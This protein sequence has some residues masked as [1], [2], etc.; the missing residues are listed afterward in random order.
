[1]LL[2]DVHGFEL[3][4]WDMSVG[5]K[6]TT[7]LTKP[8]ADPNHEIMAH[9]LVLNPMLVGQFAKMISALVQS[10]TTAGNCLRPVQLTRQTLNTITGEVQSVEM[11]RRCQSR[12]SEVCPSCSKLYRADAFAVIRAG[13]MGKDGKPRPMTMI[14]LTAPGAG[15][16]GQVHSR[17]IM[18]NGSVKPCACRWVRH[19]ENDPI[20]GTPINPETYNYAAA[21][22]FNAHA[23]RLFAVSMQKLGR[24]LRRKIQVVRVVEYQNRGLVHVH[25]LVL[26]CLTQE[27]LKLIVSG[28]RNLRTGRKVRPATS[29][30]WMWGPQCRAK[31]VAGGNPGQAIAYMV[32]VVSYA[33][34]DA[35]STLGKRNTHENKMARA[36]AETCSSNVSASGC[37]HG[38]RLHQIS[39]VEHNDIGEVRSTET[40]IYDNGKRSEYP[41]RRHKRAAAG[42]GH[43]G[44]VLTKTRSWPETFAAVRAKRGEWCERNRNRPP[45][46][47]HLLVSWSVTP[48]RRHSAWAM[49][50]G[51]PR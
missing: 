39:M 41:C 45:L 10:P 44:H 42:W 15:A 26:G 20:L 6:Q 22:D 50:T 34:K 31:V 19:A 12:I 32:K 47:S 16:F 18:D 49:A 51:P 30:R 5:F 11:L 43:R 7:E 33:L 27:S 36:G 1:V 23:S 28:G 4:G 25:A 48:H 29:G 13:L 35:G 21:A 8:T 46:P 40:F 38:N 17:H 9:G 37:I 24:I 3:G 2:L 14:T